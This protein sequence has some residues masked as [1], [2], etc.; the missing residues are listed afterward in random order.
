MK[1]CKERTRKLGR[2]VGA[3]LRHDVWLRLSLGLG[4]FDSGARALDEVGSS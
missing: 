4:C 2:V 1:W 3:C